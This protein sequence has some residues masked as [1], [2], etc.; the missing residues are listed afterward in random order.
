MYFELEY[1]SGANL[2]SGLVEISLFGITGKRYTTSVTLSS[3][4]TLSTDRYIQ[5]FKIYRAP[6]IQSIANITKA[7][8]RVSTSSAPITPS[9][10]TTFNLRNFYVTQYMCKNNTLTT[11]CTLAN[12]EKRI[13]T[14]PFDRKYKISN[15]DRLPILVNLYR[16]SQIMDLE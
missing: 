13:F 8:I 16:P 7:T 4:T 10:S 12:S 14:A 3:I 11:D 6:Q 9:T 2:T 15:I 1:D 5:P